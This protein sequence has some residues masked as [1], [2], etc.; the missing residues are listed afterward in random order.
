MPQKKK[1]RNATDHP[2]YWFAILDD[3]V[4][5]GDREQENIALQ[6][7]AR[8]GV[9]VRYIGRNQGRALEAAHA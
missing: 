3:A 1:T 8:L 9:D 5:R 2:V 7:L 6:E 4:E